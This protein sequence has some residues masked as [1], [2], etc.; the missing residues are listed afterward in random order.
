[1][2]LLCTCMF[3]SSKHE[4]HFTLTAV[5]QLKILSVSEI[6]ASVEMVTNPC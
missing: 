4:I 6:C 5:Y 2:N 1:M 3:S